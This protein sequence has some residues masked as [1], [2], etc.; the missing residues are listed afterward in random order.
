MNVRRN[1]VLVTGDDYGA[2]WNLA[3]WDPSNGTSL[4]TYKGGTSIPGSFNILGSSYVV[5]VLKNKAV[6]NVWRLDR[7]EQLPQKI[8][9]PGKLKALSANPNDG[10][11]LVGSVAESIYLWQTNTGRLLNILVRHYQESLSEVMCPSESTKEPYHIWN[12]SALEITDLVV[13][14]GGPRARIFTCSYDQHPLT[15]IAVDS[16]E[17]WI[18]LGSSKGDIHTFS[19]R[20]TPCK[21]DSIKTMISPSQKNSFLGH[22]LPISCLSISIDG[23]TLASGSEDK[24]VRIWDVKSRQTL[25]IIS[26]KGLVTIATFLSPPPRGMLDHEDFLQD[27]NLCQLE[28]NIGSNDNYTLKVSTPYGFEDSFL[29]DD[30][31]SPIPYAAKSESSNINNNDKERHGILL[32]RDIFK[33][34]MRK[35]TLK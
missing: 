32:Q 19:L 24:D 10:R 7:H 23:S 5:S 16:S 29:E 25:R 9:T 2:Q 3:V 35:E 28:K 30:T 26:M 20:D 13:G 31:L 17:V 27:L 4:V 12:D 15:S 11:F 8:T 34:L 33:L 1:E 18:Y 6:L 21:S 14:K 22:S